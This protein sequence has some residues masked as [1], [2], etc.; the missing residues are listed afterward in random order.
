MVF[1]FG[2]FTRYWTKVDIVHVCYTFIFLLFQKSKSGQIFTISQVKIHVMKTFPVSFCVDRC[3]L[4]YLVLEILNKD[5]KTEE[6]VC[7]RS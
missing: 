5:Q 1:F 7:E 3:Y 2:F 6:R 4:I